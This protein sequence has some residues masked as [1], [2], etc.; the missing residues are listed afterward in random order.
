M[1]AVPYLRE[2]TDEQ[3]ESGAGRAAQLDACTSYC[4]RLGLPM[5]EASVDDGVSG[6]AS[7]DKRPGLLDALA[8]L[9]RGDVLLVAKRD[10]L[11]RDPI[12]VAMIEAAVKR[13]GGRVVSAA[14]E[15]T[16]GDDPTSVLMR[17]IID[18][19]AEYER[20]IIKART[21]AALAAKKR[22]GQRTG[23]V[24]LGFDLADDG[25]R[26][27]AGRPIA[28]LANAGEQATVATIQALRSGGLSLRAIAGELTL[29]GVPTKDG[30]DRWDHSTVRKILNR[31]A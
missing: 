19:F 15:G 2:S 6:A 13:Q 14:G 9:E 3:A 8:R 10:R 1:K 20:L 22:R 30:L 25:Q 18:A 28:L 29:R 23:G 11:G 26:S 5:A 17:R 21:R 27:K 4:H 24:P 16:E 12:V 7:L 31:T